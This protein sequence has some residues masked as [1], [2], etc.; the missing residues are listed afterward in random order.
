MLILQ[1]QRPFPIVRQIANHLDGNTYFVRAVIRDAEGAILDTVNLDAKG[2]QRYQATWRVVPDPSGQGRY[3]SV[4]TSVFTDSGY[5][6]KSSNYGDEETTYLVFDRVMPAMRGGG[7]GN[8]DAFTIRQIVQEA[9]RELPKPEAFNYDAIPKPIEYPMR[10]DEIILALDVLRRRI[11]SLPQKGTDLSSLERSL[12]SLAKAIE[13]KPVTPAADLSPVLTALEDIEDARE[14]DHREATE[15]I[16]ALE[17][18]V[19]EYIPKA[20]ESVVGKLSL[21]SQ[22]SIAPA[23]ADHSKEKLQKSY[24]LK[25]LAS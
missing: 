21:V 19:M 20:V 13:Q 8:L 2:A 10:W 18:K 12:A 23:L 25:K 3:I 7:G 16:E 6:T 5:T 1:P 24:D 22:V 4:V 9:L 11:E 17:E 15:R 14:L